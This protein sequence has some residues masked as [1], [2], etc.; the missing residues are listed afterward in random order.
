MRKKYNFVYKTTNLLNNI[1]YVGV[2]STDDL[3]DGY[4][5]SGFL[6][7]KAINKHGVCNFKREIIKM[8]KSREEAFEVEANIVTESLIK[9]RKVYNRAP[10]GQGGYLGEEAIIKMKKSKKGQI[11]WNKGKGNYNYCNYCEKYLENRKSKICSDCYGKSLEGE[12]NPNFKGWYITPR[13]QYAS[14]ALASKYENIP[15]TTLRRWCMSEKSGYS[16]KP[17]KP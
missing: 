10:G 11:P 5:G 15:K 13:G 2:H 8:C 7:Q 14:V 9:T 16:F 12:G 4:L 3:N 6:L 1:Y 17:T